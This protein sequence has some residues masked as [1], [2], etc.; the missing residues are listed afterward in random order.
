MGF[1]TFGAL[2]TL[3]KMLNKCLQSVNLFFQILEKVENVEKLENI[4]KNI[5]TKKICLT[6]LKQT[7]LNGKKKLYK[8]E[9][10][11]S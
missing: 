6:G 9:M 7:Y 8:F 10:E 3:E 1:M 2:T 5:L 4:E 11:K